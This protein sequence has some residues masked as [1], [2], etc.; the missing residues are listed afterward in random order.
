MSVEEL[1]RLK[2]DG[3]I[4]MK[5]DFCEVCSAVDGEEHD[6]TS[7]QPEKYQQALKELGFTAGP[8]TAEQI[9]QVEARS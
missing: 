1:G 2:A 9:A 4:S 3:W 6:W 8:L 5:V 7:H